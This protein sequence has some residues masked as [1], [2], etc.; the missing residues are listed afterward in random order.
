MKI[1]LPSFVEKEILNNKPF[2][3]ALYLPKSSPLTFHRNLSR[4]ERDK[5][6]N[7]T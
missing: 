4:T 6:L 7:V 5:Q 1:V 3:A 2:C